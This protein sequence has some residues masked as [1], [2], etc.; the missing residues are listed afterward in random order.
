MKLTQVKGNT[1]VAEGGELIPFYKLEDGRCILLDTGL[2][3]EREE[4][5]QSLR[6]AG[7]TPAAILCSHTHVDHSGGAT[8]FQEKYRLPVAVTAG[9]A[10]VVHSRLNLRAAMNFSAMQLKQN[11]SHMFLQPDILL[12]DCDGTALLLDVPFRVIHTPGHS[13][14]HICVI[15]PDNVCYVGDALLSPEMYYAKLPYSMS[16]A[17]DL[18]SKQRLLG[19]GCDACI[20]AHR[21]VFTDMDSVVEANCRLFLTRA[22]EIC[23]LVDRPMPFNQLAAAV[24][25]KYDL[26]T[27][28]PLRAVSFERNVRFFVDYLLDRGDLTL[29]AGEDGNAL[30]ARR[31][32]SDD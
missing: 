25:R 29:V 20:A 2:F 9:E 30:F 28:N 6:Q 24:Y 26:F 14:S 32:V 16:I 13:P 3:R 5:D 31:S 18:E 19:L 10:A 11:Y 21:G 12:P 27:H 8:W 22:E 23:A 15:T 17:D 4:L 7:L 1:W